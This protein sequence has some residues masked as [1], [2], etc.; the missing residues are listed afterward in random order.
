MET[1]FLKVLVATEPKALEAR[2]PKTS[3]HNLALNLIEPAVTCN[4]TG[5][6]LRLVAVVLA[7][8]SVV[9]SIHDLPG[10]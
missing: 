6:H 9:A 7:V 10:A 4:V 2:P 3:I 5:G 1:G 8:V